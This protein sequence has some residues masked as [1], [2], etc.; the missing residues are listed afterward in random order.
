MSEKL[1]TDLSRFNNSWFKKGANPFKLYLWYFVRE[2]FF[3]SAFPISSV[4]VVLLKMFGARIGKNLVIKPHV[5]IKFPWK[6]KIGD[7]VWIGE[8]AW[9][10]NHALVTIGNN[11][12]ISQ[13]AVLVGGNHDYKK[14]S[15][16]LIIGEIHLKEGVW[17][18]AGAM[19][20]PGATLESHSVL[21]MGSVGSG[22]LQA[23]S[24]Y[25]GNIAVKIK[26][27]IIQS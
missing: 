17:V 26:D 2:T 8:K 18:G 4:K 21:T 9:I 7:N 19:V 5:I 14:T 27:R 22:I 23:Y 24:I 11:V 12:C 15:F 20:C 10:E 3:H 25:Q 1:K 16:D 13:G 6:L